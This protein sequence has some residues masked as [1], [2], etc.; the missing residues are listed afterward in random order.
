MPAQTGKTGL[1]AKLGAKAHQAHEANKRNEVTFDRVDLPPGIKAGLAQLVMAKWDEYKEGGL[2]GE[3]YVMLRGIAITPERFPHTTKNADGSVTTVMVPVKG[4]GV[5]LM[6]PLCDEPAK[7]KR[8]AR[9][10]EQNWGDML[11]ELGKMLNVKNM[12]D[13]NADDIEPILAMLQESKPHFLYSTR[14]YTPS[15]SK[16]RPNPTEMV[17]TQFDGVTDP[18]GTIIDPGAQTQDNSP[19][20]GA[21]QQQVES[22]LGPADNADS[23]TSSES[24]VTGATEEVVEQV[25]LAAICVLADDG[26]G[27]DESKQAAKTI[28]EMALAA[29]WTEEQIDAPEVPNWTTL[30]TLLTA[31]PAEEPKVEEP[32]KEV[33]PAKAAWSA[34]K[35]AVC[36]YRLIDPTTKKPVTDPKTKI[37]LKAKECKITAV[38][39]KNNTVDL[40]QLDDPKKVHKGIKIAD[41]E[42]SKT[43]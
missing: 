2:K 15:V 28:Q 3:P 35:D 19:G 39:T 9:S 4:Q 34:K 20:G 26:S 7:G 22:T 41:L 37:V 33:P 10:F 5:L 36:H 1:L 6:C 16:E 42:E 40:S 38:N 31:P 18:P 24:E 30:A 8:E 43:K 12:E 32:P 13:T 23:F 27:S 21:I 11:N 29:G 25:D 14:G 17:F